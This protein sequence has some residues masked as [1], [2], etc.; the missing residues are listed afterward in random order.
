MPAFVNQSYN[1]QIFAI[2]LVVNYV[3]ERFSFSSFVSMGTNMI[4]STKPNHRSNS[5]L[6]S[7]MKLRT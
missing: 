6:Y 7:L 1:I 2:T 4:A 3:G 5:F